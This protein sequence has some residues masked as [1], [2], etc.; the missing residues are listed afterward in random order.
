M[1]IMMMMMIITITMANKVE[2]NTKLLQMKE[3]LSV[4]QKRLLNLSN[5]VDLLLRQRMNIEVPS[6]TGGRI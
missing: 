6:G 2:L 1:M 4:I 5:K 3:Q